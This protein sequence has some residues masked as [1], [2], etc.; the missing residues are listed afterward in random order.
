MCI[1]LSMGL[2]TPCQL[3]LPQGQNPGPSVGFL[4]LSACL[5]PSTLGTCRTFCTRDC[6]ALL[7]AATDSWRLLHF[8][9]T[10]T[11]PGQF[12]AHLSTLDK[13]TYFG[14]RL[15][16][17]S[18]INSPAIL[19]LPV[20]YYHLPHKYPE[21]DYKIQKITCNSPVTG[22]KGYSWICHENNIPQLFQYTT[23]F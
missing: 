13:T 21:L 2:I 23:R 5:S 14:V 3:R 22:A 8:K 11:H 9:C 18:C 6:P 12:T 1:S 15:G 10:R 20:S 4:F 17:N 19:L 7:A 16:S